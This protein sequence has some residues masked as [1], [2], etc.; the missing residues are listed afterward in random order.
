M[1]CSALISEAN[2]EHARTMNKIMLDAA[3]ARDAE[4][5]GAIQLLPLDRSTLPSQ[6]PQRKAPVRGTIAVRVAAGVS[7]SSDEGATQQHHHFLEQYSE[8]AFRTLLTKA[9]VISSLARVRVECHKVRLCWVCVP[10]D[11]QAMTGTVMRVKSQLC[12]LSG[13]VFIPGRQPSYHGMPQGTVWF[14]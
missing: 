5:A 4:A 12:W 7:G 13:I 9:E 8:F 2:I 10:A 1:D 14:A 11:L 6:P 3:L